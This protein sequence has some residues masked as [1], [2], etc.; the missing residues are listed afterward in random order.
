M[1]VVTQNCVNP[2]FK[3]LGM[4]VISHDFETTAATI[5]AVKDM[6][7]LLKKEAPQGT[8]HLFNF[9]CEFQPGLSSFAQADAYNDGKTPFRPR[10]QK[11][12][13]PK[14]QDGVSNVNAPLQGSPHH[15]G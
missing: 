5:R 10:G 4:V 3:P 11:P 7:E 15:Y 13:E 9:R 8:T 6:M 2:D 1:I 14:P 12:E